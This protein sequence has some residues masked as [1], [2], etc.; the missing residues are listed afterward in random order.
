MTVS[1][2]GELICDPRLSGYDDT[3]KQDEFC[4][5]PE[6]GLLVFLSAVPASQLCTVRLTPGG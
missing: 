4:H 3:P 5:G 2:L 6:H 1:A